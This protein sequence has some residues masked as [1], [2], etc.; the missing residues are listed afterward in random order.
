M[1]IA[2]FDNTI[3]EVTFYYLIIIFFRLEFRTKTDFN[4]YSLIE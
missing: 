2:I 4:I 3:P 1:T